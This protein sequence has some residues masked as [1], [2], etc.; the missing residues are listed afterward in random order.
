MI[1]TSGGVFILWRCLP[2]GPVC[3]SRV[4]KW[5]KNTENGNTRRKPRPSIT[6][7]LNTTQAG[8]GMNQG[9]RTLKSATNIFSYDAP[10]P[11]S[12]AQ[13]MNRWSH[14]PI[15]PLRFHGRAKDNFHQ[16]TRA[17][18]VTLS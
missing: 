10:P 7:P 8:Q 1:Y 9:F 6:D 11:P 3:T 14:T 2:V 15:P 18:A 12:S 4:D 13:V 5:N 17:T 16:R